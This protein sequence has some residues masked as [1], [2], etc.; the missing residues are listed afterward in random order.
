MYL[1]NELPENKKG[2]V[3]EHITACS[4]CASTFNSIA[5][6]KNNIGKVPVFSPNPYLW[7]RIAAE[8]KEAP[9]S[10]GIFGV[11]QAIKV[12]ASAV[13]ILLIISGIVL[14]NLPETEDTASISSSTITNSIMEIP[15][16]PFNM[17]KITINFLVY[18][19]GYAW[20]APYA[21]F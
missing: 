2:I 5:K 1:D 19:N 10:P 14:Y 18:T 8:L 20:E 4:H 7:T 11:P 13:S 17:E 6:V 21:R 16:T 12:W 3:K 9:Y 15:S